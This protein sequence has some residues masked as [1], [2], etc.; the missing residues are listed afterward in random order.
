[1]SR[2]EQFEELLSR[3][4]AVLSLSTAQNEQIRGLVTAYMQ[5]RKALR[6]QFGEDKGGRKEAVKPLN[7]KLRQDI[8]ALLEPGQQGKFKAN[9][10]AY[11]EMLRG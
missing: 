2:K 5:Q 8:G 3:L 10:E 6:T 11:K 9:K 4:Q 1:M 7:Q